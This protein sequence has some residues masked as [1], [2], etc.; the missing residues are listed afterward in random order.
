MDKS[1]SVNAV[2]LSILIP[3]LSFL[4]QL[5]SL[6]FPYTI[7]QLLF[8]AKVLREGTAEGLVLYC[9]ATFRPG[10]DPIKKKRMTQK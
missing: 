1:C 6:S 5:N 9:W 10:K 2:Q 4:I 8:I 7:F 3:C